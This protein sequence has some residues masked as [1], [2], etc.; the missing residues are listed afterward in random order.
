MEQAVVKKQGGFKMI[1]RASLIIIALLSIGT[2]CFAQPVHNPD[3][4]LPGKTNFGNLS[5]QGLEVDGNPGYLELKG[6]S[7]KSGTNYT[8]YLWVRE[9]GDLMIASYATISAFSSFP[10]GNWASPSFSAGTKVGAQ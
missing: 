3:Q 7:T 10:S 5:S 2:L 8:Y 4:N 1:K 6:V 9:N